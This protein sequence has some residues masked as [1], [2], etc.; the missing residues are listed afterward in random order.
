MILALAFALSLFVAAH[1]SFARAAHAAEPDGETVSGSQYLRDARSLGA[2]G[3]YFKSA[4]YAFAAAEAD[5]ALSSDSDA[6]ITI[7]LIHANLH[8][9][10]AYF[11]IRTLQSGNKA[12]IRRVLSETQ[13]LLVHVGGDLLRKYPHP[14]HDV[15]RL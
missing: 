13:D 9:T 6:Q 14:A 3:Q 4:R 7:S 15:R 1:V 11:F 10:A 5:P 2:G 8:N 12:A